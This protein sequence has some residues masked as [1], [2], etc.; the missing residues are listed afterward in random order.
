MFAKFARARVS[1]LLSMVCLVMLFTTSCSAGNKAGKSTN[2]ANTMDSWYVHNVSAESTNDTSRDAVIAAAES[3]NSS[4]TELEKIERYRQPR[5][6]SLND[7]NMS[8]YNLGQRVA[9]DWAGPIE[10][11]LQEVAAVAGYKF[12]VVGLNPAIPVLI[13]IAHQNVELG[14]IIREANFQSKERVNLVV[15]PQS[16]TLE[17]RYNEIG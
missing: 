12:K 13:D 4:I 1:L 15:F 2:S 16:K 3:V 5:I 8:R 10:P 6:V 17:L 14:D 11:F 7:E 9:V